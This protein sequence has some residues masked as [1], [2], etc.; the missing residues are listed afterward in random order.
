MM[1]YLLVGQRENIPRLRKKFLMPIVKKVK[2]DSNRESQEKYKKK[3]SK[4]SMSSMGGLWE[5]YGRSQDKT[6]RPETPCTSA[7]QRKKG[8]LAQFSKKLHTYSNCHPQQKPAS[9]ILVSFI[10]TYTRES[11]FF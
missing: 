3:H 6:S 9:D 2:K 11:D 10:G 5:V 7:F 1:R 4:R 8:G